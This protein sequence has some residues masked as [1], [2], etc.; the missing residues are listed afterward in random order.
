MLNSKMKDAG[1]KFTKIGKLVEAS[2]VVAN[3]NGVRSIVEPQ[4]NDEL[5]KAV[6]KLTEEKI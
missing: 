3:R 2:G 4:E 1:I 5:Y 6:K